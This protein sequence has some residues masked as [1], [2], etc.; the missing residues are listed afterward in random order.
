MRPSNALCG[1]GPEWRRSRRACVFF[2]QPRKAAVPETAAVYSLSKAAPAQ[3]FSIALPSPL[4]L[5]KSGF[6]KCCDL[7]QF[8]VWRY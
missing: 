6:P 3:D 1:L 5:T 4:L 2:G 8:L 7:F